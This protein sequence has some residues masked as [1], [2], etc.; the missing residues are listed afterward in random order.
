[1]QN[2]LI[3]LRLKMSPWM[4]TVLWLHVPAAAGAAFAAGNDIWGPVLAAIGICVAATAS[5]AMAPGARSTR[6]MIAVGYIGLVSVILASCRGAPMQIDVHMYYFA[7]MAILAAFCDW[8]VILAA[9]AATAVHHLTLNFLFPALLFPDG[10]NFSRVVLHAAIVIAEAAALIWITNQIAQ[11]VG[12]SAANLAA[13]QTAI[14]QA[15]QAE[16]ET[17][18]E[19]QTAET[20]RLSAEASRAAAAREQAQVVTALAGG[21]VQLAVCQLGIRLADKFPAEYESL[22]LDFNKAAEQLQEAI[23]AMAHHTD[24]IRVG[25]REIA[26]G[27]ADLTRRTESQ[28][29]ALEETTAALDEVTAAVANTATGTGHA[30]EIVMS[31]RA[32][33]ERSGE[34]VAEAVAAMGAIDGASRQIGNIIGTIDEIAFQT[35]LLALNA[36]VEAARAGDAG[37]G[38]AVVATEVRALAQRSAEAAKEIKSLIVASEAQVKA[39]VE[40]VANVGDVLVRLANQFGQIDRV[41]GEISALANQQATALAQVNNAINGMNHTTKQTA[42]MVVQTTAASEGLD[43]E[44]QQL[45][46]LS[47]RFDG[48]TVSRPARRPSTRPAAVQFA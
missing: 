45:A 43:D 18:A 44:V 3:Q 11:L 41:V 48:G 24:A 14:E 8:E 2:D 21:L 13:A 38:F 47:D 16:A 29:A 27:N 42:A 7:A 35:N 28:A 6:L 12:R 10:A 26:A 40:R 30:R 36:G 46:A 32:D 19:R 37:R 22:R 25:A 15:R 31:A 1:M 4:I 5:W 20:I 34:V 17:N 39:G 33:S 23:A 9:A